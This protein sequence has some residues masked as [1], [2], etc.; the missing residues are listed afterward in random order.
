MFDP[1]V[2]EGVTKNG[3]ADRSSQMRAALAPVETRATEQSAL[4][5]KAKID[6]EL[7]EE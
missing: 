4:G 7:V 2:V 6:A 1:I 3:S 5:G